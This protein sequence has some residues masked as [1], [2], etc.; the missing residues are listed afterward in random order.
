MCLLLLVFISINFVSAGLTQITTSTS[1]TF[2]LKIKLIWE[3]FKALLIFIR[4][5]AVAMRFASFFLKLE[6]LLPILSVGCSSP[7]LTTSL[8]TFVLGHKAEYHI[9]SQKSWFWFSLHLSCL[10][11]SMSQ[12][13]IIL[14]FLRLFSEIQRQ[15]FLP[16]KCMGAV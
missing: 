16:Q 2:D 7:N 4:P 5:L 8:V 13:H 3:V 11:C 6:I 1:C 14:F 9:R 12:A 10:F 15:H